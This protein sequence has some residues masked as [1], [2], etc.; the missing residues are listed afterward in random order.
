MRRTLV[1]FLILFSH[2]SYYCNAWIT[3]TP[4]STLRPRF[5]SAA[6][7]MGALGSKQQPVERHVVRDSVRESINTNNHEPHQDNMIDQNRHNHSE[8]DTA[9]T[10]STED[11]GQVTERFRSQ[12]LDDTF[13][14]HPIRGST[15]EASDQYPSAG[16][17]LGREYLMPG[18]HKHLGGAYDPTDGCIYGVPANSRSVLCLYP[19]DKEGGG[20]EYLMRA[21]PLPIE[22]QEVRMKWLRGIFAHGYLWAIPSGAPKVLCVD[23]DAYWGRREE[24]PQGIVQL[25]DLPEGHPKDQIWQWH[26]AGIN[27]EKT[28]IYCIPAN[29]HQVLKVDLATK[30]TSLIPVDVDRTKYPDLD[31]TT[32]NNKWYVFLS[33]AVTEILIVCHMLC[34]VDARNMPV[35]IIF[36][37]T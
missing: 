32:V 9:D 27:H 31:V 19:Q 4:I 10:A 5:L 18:T 34:T 24:S 37:D 1:S 35:D 28:A 33:P 29:A 23:I 7:T 6:A 20:K 25:L 22:I 14:V 3:S 12:L 16:S 15:V 8:A 21:I 17:V 26:G 13:L 30:T 36:L 2:P 11:W